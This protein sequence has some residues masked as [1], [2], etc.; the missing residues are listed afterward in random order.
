[1]LAGFILEELRCVNLPLLSE[2]LPELVGTQSTRTPLFQ[3]VL[4]AHCSS[5]GISFLAPTSVALGM[6]MAASSGPQ[7]ALA[8]G[9]P[10]HSLGCM[11][12]T[13]EKPP[14]LSSPM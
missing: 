13:T 10:A 5:S 2:V 1:M 3:E 7:D 4:N 14:E 8:G 11:R 12:P 9:D 6:T